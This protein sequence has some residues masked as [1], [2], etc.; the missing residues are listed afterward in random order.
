MDLHPLDFHPNGFPTPT[1][2]HG[3]STPSMRFPYNF[4][5]FPRD[6][7]HMG[8]PSHGISTRGLCPHSRV[9][10]RVGVCGGLVGH[11]GQH[12]ARRFGWH[13]PGALGAVRARVLLRDG[14]LA[15][16]TLRM[17]PPMKTSRGGPTF[18]LVNASSARCGRLLST[19]LPFPDIPCLL[20]DCSE[21][22]AREL[23]GNARPDFRI[24]PAMPV[25]GHPL[26]QSVRLWRRPV[27]AGLTRICG[28]RD[29]LWRWNS[30]F[31][32]WRGVWRRDWHWHWHH[33]R[34]LLPLLKLPKLL[35]LPS[36]LRAPLWH[37]G[38]LLCCAVV[39][40]Y[41]GGGV[42]VCGRPAARGVFTPISVR[43]LRKTWDLNYFKL[44]CNPQA[45]DC[46]Y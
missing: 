22:L 26:N 9:W 17:I 3:I 36:N 6:F 29:W 4:P 11:A 40:V 39:V 21:G 30:H 38:A 7:H 25:R 33:G 20:F 19:L 2:F 13:A 41:G 5:G 31:Q 15:L 28:R 12:L 43:L 18:P 34:E 24:L 16:E 14:K 45:W 27:R 46:D 23:M 10:A 8:F 1:D 42:A 37:A 35:I 44:K 32:C